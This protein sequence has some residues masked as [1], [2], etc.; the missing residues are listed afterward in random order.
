[1]TPE[2]FNHL[3]SNVVPVLTNARPYGAYSMNDIDRV[4][5]VQVIVRELLETG[6]SLNG[7]VTPVLGV[8]R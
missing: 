4:G 1:M 5:G 6:L 3:S 7:D 2:E 8:P